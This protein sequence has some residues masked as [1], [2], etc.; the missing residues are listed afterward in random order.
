MDTSK[1]KS[2]TDGKWNFHEVFIEKSFKV[3]AQNNPDHVWSRIIEWQGFECL[4]TDKMNLFNIKDLVW[5]L[6]I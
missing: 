1:K 6:H 5:I 2:N 4:V 3:N